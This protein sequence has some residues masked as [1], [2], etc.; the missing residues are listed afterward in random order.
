MHTVQTTPN[1]G[2]DNDH[3]DVYNTS[4][5]PWGVVPPP[6]ILARERTPAM[7]AVAV[8]AWRRRVVRHLVVPRQNP[9]AH[10]QQRWQDGVRAVVFHGTRKNNAVGAVGVPTARLVQWHDTAHAWNMLHMQLWTTIEH[11]DLCRGLRWQWRH[12][13]YPTLRFSRDTYLTAL[14]GLGRLASVQWLMCLPLRHLACI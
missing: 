11:S 13:G 12:R 4:R 7:N 9:Q 5:H 1:R 6:C 3:M 8:R 14:C 2:W 10:A